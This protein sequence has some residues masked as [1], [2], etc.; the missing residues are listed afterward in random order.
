MSQK[1]IGG[2][3]SG[4]SGADLLAEIVMTSRWAY[5]AVCREYYPW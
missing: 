4:P 3:L 5:N 2:V 1:R